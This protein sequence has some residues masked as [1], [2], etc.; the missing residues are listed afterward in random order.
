M[1]GQP[2]P[3]CRK[4]SEEGAC[5]P[6]VRVGSPDVGACGMQDV[7]SLPSFHQCIRLVVLYTMVCSKT[8]FENFDFLV[9]IKHPLFQ[10][11]ALISIV[12]LFQKSNTQIY[13]VQQLAYSTELLVYINQ[14]KKQY[15]QRRRRKL[16]STQ[17]YSLKLSLFLC[18]RSLCSLYS[19]LLSSSLQC[20]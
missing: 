10:E 6:S 8:R 12:G 15:K 18:S 2:D 11:Q 3:F 7:G 17:L 16:F 14:S 20:V 13:V 19:L 1:S 4:S 5:G 9:W